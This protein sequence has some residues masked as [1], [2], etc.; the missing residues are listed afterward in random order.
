[1]ALPV[2]RSDAPVTRIRRPLRCELD[3]HYYV[4]TSAARVVA[5][6]PLVAGTITRLPVRP[7]EPSAR[8]PLGLAFVSDVLATGRNGTRLDASSDVGQ[9]DMAQPRSSRATAIR[10]LMPRA[11]YKKIG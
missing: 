11:M 4:E 6:L 2:L 10:P 3:A 5:T 8:E 9:I 7:R 1:M